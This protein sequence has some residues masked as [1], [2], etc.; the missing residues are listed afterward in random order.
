MLFCQAGISRAADLRTLAHR[1]KQLRVL[2]LP[3]GNDITVDAI[4]E[5]APLSGLRAVTLG[6][7]RL[8]ERGALSLKLCLSCKHSRRALTP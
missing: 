2:R 8:D 7:V 4:R 3:D 5:L 6:R 1:L